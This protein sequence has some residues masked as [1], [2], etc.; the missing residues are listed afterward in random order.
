MTKRKAIKMLKNESKIV[1]LNL[2]SYLLFLA[3]KIDILS[4][5]YDG[6]LAN[7]E[8]GFK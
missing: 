1:C 5:G 6:G 2:G 3:L 8:K 4:G 7:L